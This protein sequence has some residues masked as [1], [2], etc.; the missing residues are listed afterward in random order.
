MRRG[1]RTVWPE[2]Q[3]DIDDLLVWDMLTSQYDIRRGISSTKEPLKR[4]I[5]STL[6]VAVVFVSRQS[7]ELP[8]QYVI[9][10]VE[11]H[12]FHRSQS[13]CS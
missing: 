12:T 2:K 7:N 9:A 8:I 10:A 11:D 13:L 6:R 5:T 4:C 1:Q 3:T